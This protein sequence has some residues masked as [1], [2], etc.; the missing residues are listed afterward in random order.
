MSGGHVRKYKL[1]RTKAVHQHTKPQ[2]P[3]G[4]KKDKTTI[5]NKVTTAVTPRAQAGAQAH[6]TLGAQTATREVCVDKIQRD[7]TDLPFA[8]VR[9]VS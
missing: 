9:Y 7:T 4:T 2:G 8:S 1:S 3:R 5:G 6:S